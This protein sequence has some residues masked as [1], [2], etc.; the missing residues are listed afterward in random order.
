MVKIPNLDD[1]KKMG[2]GL[3]D[4]AKSVKFGEVVDRLKSGIES[5]GMKKGTGASS[6]GDEALES[7]FTSL[8]KSLNDLA[9]AQSAEAD[10]VKKMQAQ[11]A[12]LAKVLEP[13]QKTT[14]STESKQNEDKS[15]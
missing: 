1:L 4:S 10:I 15:S 13:Y 5:V 11:L 12:E 9:T 3:M 14:E 2:S 8:Y 6:L 7:L